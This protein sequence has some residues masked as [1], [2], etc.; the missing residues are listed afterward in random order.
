MNT[1]ISLD[2]V[3]LADVPFNGLGHVAV[4]GGG[5]PIAH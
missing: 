4:S 2:S 1:T 5:K 3:T